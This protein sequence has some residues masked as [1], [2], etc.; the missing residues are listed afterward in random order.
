MSSSLVLISEAT[1][2]SSGNITLTGMSSTYDVYQLVIADATPDTDA[3]Y[4]RMKY[5]ESGT[6]N[7]TSNYDGAEI[8]LFAASSNYSSGVANSAGY[9]ITNHT[10]GT[11]AG[12]STSANL[13]IFNSQ[14]SGEYTMATIESVSRDHGDESYGT[15]GGMVFTVASTVDGV[16]LYYTSGN[17]ASGEFKLYGLKK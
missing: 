6:K 9:N 3:A 13:Y 15:F 1:A 16:Y 8:I 7:D 4:L 11:S 14:D 2:S 5:T 10:N 17:I 12:E